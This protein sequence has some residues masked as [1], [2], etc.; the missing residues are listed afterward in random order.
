M[1]QKTYRLYTSAP[2]EN[3]NDDLER[4]KEQRLS[5]VNSFNNSIKNIQEMTKYLKDEN[6]KSKKIIKNIKRLLQ[7]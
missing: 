5:D 2:L 3:K 1:E 4:R 7:Y 6:N